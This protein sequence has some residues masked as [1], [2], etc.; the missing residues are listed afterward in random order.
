[1]VTPALLVPLFF[2]FIGR[3]RMS[4]KAALV[5]IVASGGLSL[6]WLV[7]GKIFNPGGYFLGIAAIFPGLVISVVIFLLS[8]RSDK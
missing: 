1:M 8:A 2:T 4:P 7:L 5:C 6:V 3:K